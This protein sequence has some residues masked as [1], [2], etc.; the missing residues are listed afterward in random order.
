MTQYKFA[1][2]QFNS[3]VGDLEGN[4][5][6]HIAHIKEAVEAGADMVVFPEMSLTG[7]PLEDLVLRHSFVDAV[8]DYTQKLIDEIMLKWPDV[9]VIFGAPRF[10]AGHQT[11]FNSSFFINGASNSEWT[12][13]QIVDKVELPNYGVFDEKRVFAT[14][15]EPFP[16]DFHGHKIG[17]L[18]CED[19]WFPGVSRTLHENGAVMLLSVNGSPYEM[20][21]NVVR[22]QV[23]ANRIKET[24]LP[25][26]YVNMVGGQDELVFDGGSFYWDGKVLQEA[27]HFKA[28]IFYMD[29]TLDKATSHLNKDGR[30]VARIRD[31]GTFAGWNGDTD[32]ISLRGYPEVQPSGIKEVYQAIH[33]GLKDYML[34][35][36]SARGVPVFGRAVLGYSGGVDSGIVASVACDAVGPENVHLVRLPSKYSSEG[37]LTDA[38]DGA[39]RLGAPMR[40]IHIE[41]VVDALRQAYW[42]AQGGCNFY[43][44]RNSE[45]TGVADENIQARARGNILMA[46]SNQEG[47]LLLTTGNKSEVS[48]GY[49]TLYGDMSGGY[50]PIKDA[51]KTTVWELCRWRNSLTQEELNELG[52]LGRATE[53]VP[54]AIISKP[55]SAELR[56]DQK[57][58]DSLPPY[59]VLDAILKGMIELEKSMVEL[60]NEGFNQEQ[61]VR[62]RN[63]IDNAEYK[64]RQAAPGVKLTSKI[65]GRDR[66]YPIVNAWRA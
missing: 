11:I 43:T 3:I 44:Y 46:I 55:P 48:V 31:D 16:I 41:P 63:L 8:E 27:P 45:L 64:R 36:K 39:M 9:G 10:R 37:S 30:S 20:G 17:L 40:T 18:I 12:K 32:V 13:V 50:N 54:E 47:H 62:V 24:G 58:E 38:E 57:D 52:F 19:T 25:L 66:R 61:V 26:M 51:Y 2:V 29:V 14:G 34:K 4:Y 15:G 60:I 7:Y 35:Q 1:I 5:L 65:H 6:G 22:R 42:G 49:S 56:P 28:G 21:K 33:L 59:P 53:V 23:A